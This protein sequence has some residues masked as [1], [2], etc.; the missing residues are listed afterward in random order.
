MPKSTPTTPSTTA[1][2]VRASS[3]SPDRSLPPPSRAL[4]SGNLVDWALNK[5][6][7]VSSSILLG[8]FFTHWIVDYYIIW[9]GPAV[10]QA[11]VDRALAYYSH[12]AL[13]SSAVYPLGLAALAGSALLSCLIKLSTNPLKGML[14]DGASFLLLA[15]GLSVYA[16]NVRT[17]L[18]YLPGLGGTTTT[19]SQFRTTEAL[20]SIAASN[21]IICVSLTGILA[22]QAAQGHSDRR[23]KPITVVRG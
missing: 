12:L 18:A 7:F 6:I 1:A 4:I 17:A 20:Q 13:Q 10:S 22:L 11:S 3:P 19:T 8:S 21:L 2:V 16:S 5:V 23:A 15:S 9:Q 14:F